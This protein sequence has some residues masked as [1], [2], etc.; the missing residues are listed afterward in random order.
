MKISYQYIRKTYILFSMMIIFVLSA[1]TS[2]YELGNENIED[3]GKTIL[4]AL[5]TNDHD[6]F[7]KYIY[8][9]NKKKSTDSNTASTAVLSKTITP[10]QRQLQQEKEEEQALRE[11]RRLKLIHTADVATFKT[12]PV[13]DG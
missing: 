5:K 8:F 11:K 1:C 13:L 10:L 7:T 2:S 12:R 9:K 4:N 6:L 3:F